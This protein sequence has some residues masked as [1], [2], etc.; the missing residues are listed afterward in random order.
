MRAHKHTHTHSPCK[1]FF[2]AGASSISCSRTSTRHTPTYLISFLCPSLRLATLLTRSVC[3]LSRS[4]FA[5]V[6]QSLLSSPSQ[7]LYP[8]FTHFNPIQTQMFHVAYHTSFNVL[9]GAPTGSGKTVAAE[10]AVMHLMNSCGRAPLG[11]RTPG[12][13]AVHVVLSSLAEELANLAHA[14]LSSHILCHWWAA[15]IYSCASAFCAV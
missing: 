10:L 8:G 5:R 2:C 6:Y 3:L 1:N 9:L 13:P 15:L 11:A 12:A 4:R 14:C 7:A